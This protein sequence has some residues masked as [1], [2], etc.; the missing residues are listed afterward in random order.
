MGAVQ[1]GDAQRLR[2][3]P[4]HRRRGPI[5]AGEGGRDA[6]GYAKGMTRWR[7]ESPNRNRA[8]LAGPNRSR[9]TVAPAGSTRS[10]SVTNRGSNAI[11]VGVPVNSTGSRTVER[12][13][14]APAVA[15]TSVP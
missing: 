7:Y 6:L 3:H 15:R 9:V 8:G 13:A 10:R 12:P 11:S 2:R 5:E 1:G 4:R 14:V